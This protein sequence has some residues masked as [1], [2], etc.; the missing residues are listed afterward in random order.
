MSTYLSAINTIKKQNPLILQITN[1][2]TIQDC[3]NITICFGASPVMSDDANDA[4][5]LAQSAD[6]LLLNIGTVNH[7]QLDIMCAAADVAT[8]RAIPMILDPVGAGATA[9]R[10]QAV[11]TLIDRY[12]FA[13]IKGNAGE[14]NSIAGQ[15]ALVR[16]VDS[17]DTLN[18]FAAADLSENSG[19][20]I[21]VSGK[22]DTVTNGVS[23]VEIAN[24]CSL[25][26]TI[27]GTGCMAG[28][29]TAVFCTA[30]SAFDAAAFAFSA[31]GVCAE[32]AAKKAEGPGSFKPAFFDAAANLTDDA[33]MFSAKIREITL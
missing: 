10:T 11:H 8:D 21:A 30:L 7:R 29:C 14:I 20:I 17:T 26:G 16:G 22:T 3:A 18:L 9:F 13:V 6:A 32:H 27:S 25:M 33:L 1:A 24:G 4:A 31:M 15:H 2:V 12:S 28:C 19:A 23:A 5:E